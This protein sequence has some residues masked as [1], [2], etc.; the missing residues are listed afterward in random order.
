MY[1]CKPLNII[2]EEFM[3]LPGIGIKTAER[4]AFYLVFQDENFTREFTENLSES[5][6][7]ILFCSICGNLDETDPCSICQS[8]DRDR[9]SICIV[10]TPK[11]LLAIERSR[12]YNG[13]YHVLKG[14]LSPTDGMTADKLNINTLLPRLSEETREI[15]IATNSNIP[16]EM[17]ALF[18]KRLLEPYSCIVTRIGK[19][20]PFGGDLE[21]SDQMTIKNAFFNRRSF[22]DEPT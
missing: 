19:G 8:H 5:R 3:K 16:G 7:A 1:H 10:E 18:L 12:A 11:D 9:H 22:N 21:F 13:Y 15:I 17:T 14:A 20:L 4:L 2:I 6:K